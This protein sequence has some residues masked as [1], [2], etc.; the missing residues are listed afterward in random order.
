LL[1][2]Y[3]FY[4]SLALGV[5]LRGVC[6]GAATMVVDSLRVGVISADRALA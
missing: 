3:L 5:R 1:G 4:A 2:V 6:G